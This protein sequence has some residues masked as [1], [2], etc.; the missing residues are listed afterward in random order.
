MLTEEAIPVPDCWHD[1]FI[2]IFNRLPEALKEGERRRCRLHTQDGA[3][4]VFVGDP[5]GVV[6]THGSDA[7]QKR[8]NREEHPRR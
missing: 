1:D 2:D 5:S 4:I 8:S 6:E 3:P 7:P